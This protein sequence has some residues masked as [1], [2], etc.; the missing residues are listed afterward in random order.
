MIENNL[1]RELTDNEKAFIIELEE[2]LKKRF[3]RRIHQIFI[4]PDK[5]RP[6]QVFGMLFNLKYPRGINMTHTTK[7]PHCGKENTSERTNC[8]ECDQSL[9]PAGMF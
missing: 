2:L 3:D 1:D 8:K 6:G 7:C 5:E 4:N 9:L